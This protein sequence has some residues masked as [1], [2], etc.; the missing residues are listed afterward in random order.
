MLNGRET[1]RFEE[2]RFFVALRMTKDNN[3]LI[4]PIYL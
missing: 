4:V 1:S 3:T 2:L